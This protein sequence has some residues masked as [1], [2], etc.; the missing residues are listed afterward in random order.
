MSFPVTSSQS[1]PLWVIAPFFLLAPLGLVAGGLLLASTSS[2]ALVAINA[3][4][5]VAITHAVVIGWITTTVMG[6]SYQLGSAV[7]GG[8]LLSIPLARFQL[9]LHGAAVVGFVWS[10]LEWNTLAMSVAGVFLVL[11]FTLYVANVA[12]SLVR[13]RTWSL[14]RAYLVVSL[15][16]LVLTAS[17]GITWVGALDHLWFPITMGRLSAHAHLGLMGWLGITVMGVSY[18]LVPMFNVVNRAKPRVG[19]LALWVT[20]AA[21]LLFATLMT[22][23]PGRATRV[24]LAAA[25][26]VGPALWGAEQTR[27]MLR[28]SRRN[29]DIQGRSTFVSLSFLVAAIPLGLAAAWGTPFTPDGE[30]ARWLLAYAACGVVG[31]IGITVL[32]NT[33]KIL[34]FLIWFHRYRANVGLAPVP[35]MTDIYSER[36]AHG[37]MVAAA[38]TAVVVALGAIAG[39][40]ALLQVGGVLLAITGGAHGLALLHMFLPKQASQAGIPSGQAVRTS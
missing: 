31:W 21:T 32:G 24:F 20:V 14:A 25:L 33:Y 23:D 4:R 1:P 36:V 3:P 37:V 19:R 40:L 26:A 34:P 13:G 10:L 18:Q 15:A 16:M 22:T 9:W 6:A 5:T 17:L 30:P 38:V 28:R 39:S 7:I 12:T 11:S 27:L 2:D 35:M 8:R 29:M